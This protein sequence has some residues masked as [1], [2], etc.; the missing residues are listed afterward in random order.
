MPQEESASGR[1]SSFMPMNRRKVAPPKLWMVIFIAVVA[2]L[3]TIVWLST[4]IWLQDNV[5][6][7]DYVIN[8]NRWLVPV[9]VIV[10]SLGVGLCVKYLRAPTAADGSL[11][12]SMAGEEG[13]DYRTFPGTLLTSFFSLLSGAVVGPEG[14][15]GHLVMEI[16]AWFEHRFK[17]VKESRVGYS[18]AALASA[19]NGI[20]GNPVFSAV[21]AT[22]VSSDK[23]NFS[24]II[25]NLLAGVI[26]FLIFALLGFT[27]FLG[28]IQ[29]G[30]IDHF[31][32]VYVIYALVFGVI[33]AFLALFIAGWFQLW[34][35]VLAPFKNKV[36][37]RIM[38]GA[39]IIAI[40]VYL[41][42]EV[43]FS[44][45]DQI[46]DIIKNAAT[47]GV[48]ML[49]LFA[50]LKVILFSLSFKS[51]Y[52]GGPIFPTLF[53]CTMLA[54]AFSLMFPDIPIIIIVLCIE[55]AA[56]ALA[57]NAPLTSVLLVTLV[58]SNGEVNQYLIGLVVLATVISM[59]IGFSFKK[60]MAS[61]KAEKGEEEEDAA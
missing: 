20:I 56:M 4:W 31:D 48:G 14:P 6:W 55:A 16:S 59:I 11:A 8:D 37:Q 52:L 2:I 50:L 29:F 30:T 39:V 3:F 28:A 21:F 7:T 26:G 9:L 35:K 12:D 53:T 19:Y 47:Y 57:L 23:K 5:I 43:M 42:P 49:L 44:G 36:M 13:V 54:L 58:A 32:L 10:I 60:L 22:E 46:S 33:G 51:G 38:I 24:F 27:S 61:R 40:V 25:W 34:G 15:L 45:E 1:L 17:L 18:V 41:V